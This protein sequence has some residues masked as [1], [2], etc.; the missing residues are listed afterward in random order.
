MRCSG[1]RRGK[2]GRQGRLEGRRWSLWVPDSLFWFLVGLGGWSISSFS[3]LLCHAVLVRS[4]PLS[5]TGWTDGWWIGP[6]HFSLCLSSR[7]IKP[8]DK[9]R[10]REMAQEEVV[11]MQ[12]PCQVRVFIENVVPCPVFFFFLQ[13]VRLFLKQTGRDTGGSEAQTKKSTPPAA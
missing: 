11:C 12:T 13:V 7:L 9:E 6:L 5:C 4:L 8:E 1:G 3:F 2:M 10:K